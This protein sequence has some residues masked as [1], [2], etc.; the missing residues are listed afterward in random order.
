MVDDGASLSNVW[1]PVAG[2]WYR[3]DH[4]V[5]D[6]GVIIEADGALKYDNQSRAS[7]LISNDREREEHLRGLG[8]GIARYTWGIAEHHPT[9]LLARVARAARMRGSQPPPTC[10]TLDSPYT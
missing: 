1:I 9:M 6:A 7:V 8:F 10:W 5:P 4:L 2:R 3:V